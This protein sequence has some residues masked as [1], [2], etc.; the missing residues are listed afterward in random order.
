[1]VNVNLAAGARIIGFLFGPDNLI[2][3]FQWSH[4]AGIPDKHIP[5]TWVTIFTG[6]GANLEASG[7]EPFIS[8]WDD[9]G[10]RIGQHWVEDNRNKLP[11]SN[12]PNENIYKIPHTQNRDPMATA[13]YV[14]ISQLYS[15]TICISA[16]QVSN[17][18]LSATWY[19]D[20]AMYCGAKWF[21]SQ[22][23]VGDKYPKCV[24]MSAGGIADDYPR[25]ISFH[26]NDMLGTPS[27]I[28]MYRKDQQKY[29]CRSTPRFGWWRR[30]EPDGSVPFFKPPLQYDVDKE[31][32]LEGCDKSSELAVDRV[33]WDKSVYHRPKIKSIKGIKELRRSLQM[34]ALS[35]TENVLS[36]RRGSN[37]DPSHL[38]VTEAEGHE[39]SLVCNSTTSEG[40]DVVSL[41]EGKYCDMEVKRLY[42]LCT[43]TT[44]GNCFDMERKVL[45]GHSGVDTRQAVSAGEALEKA[46]RTTE[47]WSS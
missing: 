42:D 32:G 5:E 27:K 21:L 46:Y 45:V 35:H 3:P 22:R 38:I 14:M 31:T 18:K 39:A 23:K 29:L 2:A 6:D 44:V 28:Q 8:L 10:R 12:D 13:Q 7:S 4:D 9:G 34:P 15:E 37:R 20:L 17:G 33:E 16:V 1:M 30:L 47:Y 36:K 19:G 41:R 24:Y 26:V 11:V 25:S 40:W 43:L